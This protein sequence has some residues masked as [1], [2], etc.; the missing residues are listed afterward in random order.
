M[1]A[2]VNDK[3]HLTF[4]SH[5]SGVTIIESSGFYYWFRLSM[6]CFYLWDC[7]EIESLKSNNNELTKRIEFLEKQLTN[8][9]NRI[10]E[11]RNQI[12]E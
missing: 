4:V 3:N 7:D 6:S 11:L 1:K 8:S 2:V 12:E 5:L 10:T 9:G